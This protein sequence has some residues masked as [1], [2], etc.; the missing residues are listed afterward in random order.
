M[1]VFEKYFHSLLL[2]CKT[3]LYRFFMVKTSHSKVCN[4]DIYTVSTTDIIRGM[5]RY[6]KTIM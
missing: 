4:T 1:L 6:K 3:L 5:I 2:R